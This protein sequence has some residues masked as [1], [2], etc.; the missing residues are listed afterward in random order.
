MSVA[1]HGDGSL[2][3]SSDAQRLSSAAAGEERSDETDVGCNELS[4]G[5]RDTGVLAIV[6]IQQL[7]Q[8]M[9]AAPEPTM[10]MTTGLTAQYRSPRN[11]L[12]KIGPIILYAS[13]GRA[14]GIIKGTPGYSGPRDVTPHESQ[15]IRTVP[16]TGNVKQAI[17]ILPRHS[18][19]IG[20]PTRTTAAAD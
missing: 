18:A 2:G 19:R 6:V 14:L 12:K 7:P 20:M 8:I 4:A 13:I 3:H 11:I 16:Q 5:A 17:A 1:I 15:T 10:K 9:H